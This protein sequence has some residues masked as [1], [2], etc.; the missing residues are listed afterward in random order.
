MRIFNPE[1]NI[2]F[3]IYL[4]TLTK[5][6]MTLTYWWNDSLT[7]LPTEL[8]EKNKIDLKTLVPE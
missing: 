1:P 5:N 6:V 4:G 8:G 3:L 7:K 2:C